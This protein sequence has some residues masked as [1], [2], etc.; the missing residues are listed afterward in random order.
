[1][2]ESE[3]QNLPLEEMVRF[4][5]GRLNSNAAKS[6]GMFPFFTCSQDTYRTDTWSFDGEYVLLAGNNAAG[7]YP[8]KYFDG[9]FDAYQRTYAIRSIDEEKLLTRYLYY[10]LR[11]QLELMKSISTGVATKF[12]TLSLLDRTQIPVPP[13]S[14]QRK[15]VAILSAYDDLIENNLRRVKIL[16]EMAQD[17]YRE[18]FVKFRFPGLQDC[19]FI[20]SELGRIPEG[21]KARE[22]SDFVDFVRGI[23][24]GSKSYASQP[25]N[26][27][28]PFLRV[29]DL[30]KRASDLFIEKSLAKGHVL[31]PDDIA[32]TMDGTVGLVSMGLAGAYST[33]I[34]RVV[35]RPNCPVGRIF[36]FQVLRSE[37]MQRIIESHAKGTTIKHA[38]SSIGHM[39]FVLPEKAVADAFE[40]YAGPLN[41]LALSLRRR[42]DALRDTRDFLLPK[43]ISGE[44]DVSELDIS[45]SDEAEA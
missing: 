37:H 39:A 6:D 7:V 29:G 36:L 8:L 5:T 18:W 40:E 33:G 32:I 41:S 23:E 4:K 15:T 28:V 35:S 11:L 38:G 10:A 13:I 25:T 45:I 17:L 24:P 20:D 22:L 43:L 30:G 19:R 34:R 1:M 27:F 2:M 26:G 3:F 31:A 12:L 44:V 42:N 21:W 16:E 14:T 9:K